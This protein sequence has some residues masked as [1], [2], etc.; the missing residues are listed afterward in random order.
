MS[1]TWVLCL[2]PTLLLALP[3]GLQQA[4][5][6][7]APFL[8]CPKGFKCC[9]DTCCPEYQ[10]EPFGFF[11]GPF[12]IFVIIFLIFISLMCICGLAKHIFRNCREP[13][14]EPPME[15]EGPPELPSLAPEERVIAPIS[16]SPPPYSEVILK[17]ELGLPPTEPP[18]PYSCRPEEYTRAC[19][20]IDNPA[21]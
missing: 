19:R 8:T 11:S 7:C 14:H 6:T 17:P 16:D 10:R 3:A 1:D 15:H 13:E 12:R 18:P 2:V 9:G 5:A 20:G 4:A 21:F